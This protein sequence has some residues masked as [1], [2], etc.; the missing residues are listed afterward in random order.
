MRPGVRHSPYSYFEGQLK[1]SSR[2]HAHLYLATVAGL[3]IFTTVINV[4]LL[5]RLYALY[6]SSVRVLRFLIT[7]VFIEFVLELYTTVE[8][9]ISEHVVPSNPL[10]P[11]PGCIIQSSPHTSNLVAW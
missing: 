10:I 2:C 8:T 3:F 1:R 11:Y 5:L 6:E 9:L 4:I 7:V